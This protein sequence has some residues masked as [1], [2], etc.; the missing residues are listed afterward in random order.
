MIDV[1]STKRFNECLHALRDERARV[2][3]VRLSIACASAILTTPDPWA[4]A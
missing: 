3:I 2:K 4:K 1:R